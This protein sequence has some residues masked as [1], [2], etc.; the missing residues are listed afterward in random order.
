ML[1]RE[2]IIEW[3]NES[4]EGTD[5][6]IVDVV[7]KNN[8][9]IMVFLDADS[10]LG[11]DHCVEVSRLI[12]SKLNRDEED[13]ELRVSSA[14]L[15]HPFLLTRQYIK[16]IGRLLQVELYDGTIHQGKIVNADQEAVTIDIII[17]KRRNKIKQQEKGG[18]MVIAYSDIKE[19]RP[20]ISFQ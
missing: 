9:V 15:D 11:I 7:I 4:L 18:Q 3:V 8:E 16:N 14:G 1:N 12:E 2:Q 6:F 19:G 20:L 5:R 10:G 17:E 13:Y